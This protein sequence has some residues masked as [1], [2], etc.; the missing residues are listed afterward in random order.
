VRFVKI[1]L[2]VAET[3]YFAR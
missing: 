2:F 3:L 1:T